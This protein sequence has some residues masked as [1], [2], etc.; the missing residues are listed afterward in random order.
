MVK[1]NVHKITFSGYVAVAVRRRQD[2]NI[3]SSGRDS[4]LF[5]GFPQQWQKW[6]NLWSRCNWKIKVRERAQWWHHHVRKTCMTV[7]L[8][9]KLVEFAWRISFVSLIVG[10]FEGFLVYLILVG[11]SNWL[12]TKKISMLH[13]IIIVLLYFSYFMKQKTNTVMKKKRIRKIT[14]LKMIL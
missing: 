5:G 2:E 6:W 9:N 11:K 14:I 10:T 8:F 4:R 7:I 3:H 13:L 12:T 1:H